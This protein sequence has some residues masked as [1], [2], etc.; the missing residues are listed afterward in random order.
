MEMLERDFDGACERLTATPNAH[1]K[2]RPY[3]VEANTA[4]EAAIAARKREML[5]AMATGTGK[6]FTMVNQ[7]YRLMKSDVAKRILFLVDRRALA[8]QAVRAFSEFEPEPGLKF[9]NIYEVYSQRFQS[10]DF[11]ASDHFDPTVMP[12]G[13]LTDPQPAHAF[14]YVCT[15]Q[16]MTANLFG[17]D[18]VMAF[19]DE[20][21]DEDAEQISIPIH[22]FD[23]I[24]AD[25]CHRGYTSQELSIW[26][27]TL[28]HFDAIKI[29]LTATPASHTTGYFKELAYRYDY[30]RAVREGYLVDYDVVSIKSDVRLHGVF[31]KEGEEVDVVDPERGTRQLDL[32]EDERTFTDTE[33]ERKVT[34][35][36]SNRKILRELK[37]YT[38]AHEAEY[39][40]F[41]K[42]LIFAVNDIP[43]QSHADQLVD[44]ARDIFGRGDGFVE[45]I[46]GKV[47]RPLQ[48]I[49]EF[50]NRPKPG[51]V[52]TVDL[53]TTGIDV[54]DL[55]FIVFLRPVK[56]RILFTQMLGRGTRKSDNLPDKSHFTV[57]D[58]F[59][60]TLLAYF[61][62][63]TDMTGEDPVPPSRTLTE[64]IGDI[65]ANR[66]RDYNTRVLVKRLHRIDKEMPGEARDLFAAY[67]PDGD[68]AQYATVLPGRL[69]QAFT[70]TMELLRDSGF[71]DLLMNF[72]RARRAPFL[73]AHGVEDIVSSEWLIRGADGREY[74]PEE[75]L[76][77]FA[78]YVR[79]N[80]AHIEAIR[81]LLDRPRQWGSQPLKEL[82]DNL[83]RTPERFDE[84][85]LQRAHEA[86]YR[87]PLIDIISMVKHA[88][89]E[90][91]DLFTAEERVNL[92]IA[93]LTAGREFS[94]DQR[95]WLE[96]IRDHLVTNLSIDRADF[97]T[98]FV[99]T[100]AGG[101]APANRAFGGQLETL[102]HD[103]NEAVAA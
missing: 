54:P 18:A 19:G 41:P 37:S 76:A 90:A 64:I 69:R 84:T 68:L 91:R 80:P 53:L 24:I 75:Y 32:L 1:K 33:V 96:R 10:G 66:D 43:Q 70:A 89:D 29:G 48:H 72:P 26:R 73:V 23:L 6:T 45:K 46:T 79:D 85:T 98:L 102:I 93:K 8:A 59:D 52:V 25:E 27:R 51:I 87:K 61:R 95:Q 15:I 35:P 99:F 67:V 42:T 20:A 65:W 57:F 2:L 5:I 101:W 12:N 92:A 34:A 88:A 4:T 103:I 94:A 11:E 63:A 39:G 47:D 21:I 74:R 17:R 71:Q 83:L 86:R 30:E 97:D 55:E 16:R 36:D 38:D 31:L 44:L 13:Y 77:S 7:V 22:A 58:C 81:I 3:Q 9:N 28:D 56:S 40:R 14:V 82:R 50:R 100:R 62:N 49:R 60:G 78:R